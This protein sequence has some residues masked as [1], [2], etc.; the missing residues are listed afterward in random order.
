LNLENSFS[1]PL[2]ETD[3]DDNKG[4]ES[5]SK[6]IANF[7]SECIAKAQ[8]SLGINLVKESRTIYKCPEKDLAVTCLVSKIYEKKNQFWFGIR[9]H[10]I[11]YLRKSSESLFLFGCNYGDRIENFLIPASEILERLNQ[12][13][14]SELEGKPPYWHIHIYPKPKWSIRTQPEYKDLNIEKFR[15]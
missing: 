3:S 11:E 10:Q 8:V 12:F 14:S 5:K 9:T 2:E 13:N 4:K 6:V 1:E 7:H 15:V